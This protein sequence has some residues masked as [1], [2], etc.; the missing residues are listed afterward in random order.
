MVLVT[1]KFVSGSQQWLRFHY[2]TLQQNVRNII[3]K[4]DSYFITK[5]GSFFTKC[6]VYYKIVSVHW[7]DGQT[8]EWNINDQ[9]SDWEV[10]AISRNLKG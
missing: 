7:L 8:S 6:D 9:T 3:T 1:N 4:C 10:S 5:C 2:D